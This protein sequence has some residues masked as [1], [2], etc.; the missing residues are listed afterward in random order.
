[1][2]QSDQGALVG[3]ADGGPALAGIVFDTPSRT[4]V[5][6]ALVD[7]VKGAVFRTVSPKTL[8]EREEE[9]DDDRALQLLIR[10]T[11]PPV[12]GAIRGGAR[13]GGAPHA[14]PLRGR[15]PTCPGRMHAGSARRPLWMRSGSRCRAASTSAGSSS[16]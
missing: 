4:K 9:G 12:H 7:P 5:V 3:G 15:R 6:V 8:T 14:R 11:P 1:M 13:G 16:P 10:R 2:E